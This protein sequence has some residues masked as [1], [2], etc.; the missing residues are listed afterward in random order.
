MVHTVC[1]SL[2]HLFR[3]GNRAK[4]LSLLGPHL[5]TEQVTWA[6]G[7]LNDIDEDRYRIE[8]V[9]ALAPFLTPEQRADFLSQAL[10]VHLG[11]ERV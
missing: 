8:A 9:A 1:H 11:A 2:A 10:S 5:S 7:A 6:F 3:R 4:A